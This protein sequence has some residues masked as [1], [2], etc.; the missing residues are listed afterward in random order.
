ME[1]LKINNLSYGYKDG[2]YE[3]MLLDNV[4]FVIK[5]GDFNI[6]TGESGTGKTS[7]LYLL[8]GLEKKYD[9]DIYYDG[10]DIRNNLDLYRKKD[11]AMIFQNYNLIDYLSVINNI[12]IA[13]QIK[14]FN[15]PDTKIKELLKSIKIDETKFNRRVSILSGGEKQRVAIARALLTDCKIIIADEA[16]A[17][18]DGRLSLDIINLFRNLSKENNKTVILAT[19]NKEICKYGDKCFNIENKK[20]ILI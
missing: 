9:G 14:G 20:V 7:L 16:T 6:I 2:D 3:N 19:H 1:I 17:N 4:S 15:I 5:E 18:L 10:K 12:R 11:V 8:A 13:L